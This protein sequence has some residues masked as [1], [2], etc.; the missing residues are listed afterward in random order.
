MIGVVRS[1]AALQGHVQDWFNR[2]RAA[3][4]RILQAAGFTCASC[5][6][7]SPPAKGVLHAWLV[8]VDLAQPGFV[9]A[10]ERGAKAL[11]PVCL[12]VQALNWALRE[13]AGRGVL[14]Y[15]P[16]FSQEVVTRMAILCGCARVALDA[17]DVASQIASQTFAVFESMRAELVHDPV[18]AGV[19]S[20]ADFAHALAYLPE[21]EYQNRHRALS[22]IKYLPSF[23]VHAGFYEHLVEH[24]PAY[25][26]ERLRKETQALAS[27]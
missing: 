14:I 7:Q 27:E 26:L 12:G 3:G 6:V 19:D 24:N 2:D 22:N 25:R 20:E 8:P 15:A 21:V 4:L 10:S 9:P 11:C 16:G 18:Y 13:D 5:G 23:D 1:P 17:A